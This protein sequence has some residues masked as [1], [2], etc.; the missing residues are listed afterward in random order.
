MEHRPSVDCWDRDRD[1]APRDC[2]RFRQ[3]LLCMFDPEESNT[4]TVDQIMGVHPVP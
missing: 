4:K 3:G 2:R 1:P